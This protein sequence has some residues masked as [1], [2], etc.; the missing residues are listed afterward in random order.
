MFGGE[1]A[2]VAVGYVIGLAR[3]LFVFDRGIRAGEC[4]KPAGMSLAG[5]RVALV[6]SGD[7]GLSV[8]K[9]LAALDMPIVAYD[10][11]IEGDGGIEG[12]KRAVWPH[13]SEER[14]LGTEVDTACRAGWAPEP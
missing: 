3:Q 11:G 10:P 2:D 9:R 8:A 6:G 4:P 13:S 1:V 14:R 7:L 5:K 12:V